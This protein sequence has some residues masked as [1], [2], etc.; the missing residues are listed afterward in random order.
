MANYEELEALARQLRDEFV[1]TATK[2]ADRWMN[3]TLAMLSRLSVTAQ[4]T[5]D[6]QKQMPQPE[7]VQEKRTLSKMILEAVEI[8][9]NTSFTT[10]DVQVAIRGEYPTDTPARRSN[11]SSA[12]KRL[13]KDQR[14]FELSKKGAGSRPSK[15]RKLDIKGENQ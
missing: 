1:A 4:P 12:I 6:E 5:S 13:A 11:V 7:S 9:P 10:K 8:L 14:G 15:Y 3:D 2:D